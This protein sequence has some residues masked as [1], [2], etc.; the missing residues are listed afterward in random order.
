MFFK[1][2]WKAF[3]NLK[4]FSS[5]E[6]HLD[7]SSCIRRPSQTSGKSPCDVTHSR[8]QAGPLQAGESEAPALQCGQHL[9]MPVMVFWG[10]QPEMKGPGWGEGNVLLLQAAYH[11]GLEDAVAFLKNVHTVRCELMTTLKVIS[12]KTGVVPLLH[13]EQRARG[14]R[15][16]VCVLWLHTS[17]V[18]CGL[19][20]TFPM[21]WLRRKWSPQ[22][23]PAASGSLITVFQ[24]LQSINIPG[25]VH[26]CN[27]IS[28]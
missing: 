15:V 20:V 21:F 25:E 16:C 1:T 19:A 6:A 2:N 7:T 28:E 18:C 12:S 26:L 4:P 5:Q 22:S 14:G 23:R 11:S 13:Q 10:L 8:A 9:R 3:E 17:W 24:T 27:L